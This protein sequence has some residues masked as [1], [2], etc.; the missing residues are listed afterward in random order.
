MNDSQPPDDGELPTRTELS[1]RDRDIFLAALADTESKPNAALV[2]AAEL[3]KAYLAT[4]RWT[5]TD[6][7]ASD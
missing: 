5:E 7:P 2:A 3:Y 1:D 6:E 4:G